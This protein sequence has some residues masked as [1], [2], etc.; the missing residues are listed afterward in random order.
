MLTWSHL[1]I[2]IRDRDRCWARSFTPHWNN[3]TDPGLRNVY[4]VLRGRPTG[5][6]EKHKL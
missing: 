3:R 5:C 1:M 4:I 6:R 2:E